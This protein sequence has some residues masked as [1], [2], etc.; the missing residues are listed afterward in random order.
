MIKK[1]LEEDIIERYCNDEYFDMSIVENY[2][3]DLRSYGWSDVKV[4]VG[5]LDD[6]EKKMVS[7]VCEKFSGDEFF[8]K[9]YAYLNSDCF[10]NTPIKSI[11]VMQNSLSGNVNGHFDIDATSKTKEEAI[12][13]ALK[14]FHCVFNVHEIELP[15]FVGDVD[16][17]DTERIKS[18]EKSDCVDV[19]RKDSSDAS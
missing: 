1:M 4:L 10:D 8:D 7:S 2:V 18:L 19:Y 16:Y 5:A 13:N 14:Y 11:F 9:L 17:A 15:D 12:K 6:D 3:Y